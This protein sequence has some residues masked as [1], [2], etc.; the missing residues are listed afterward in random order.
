M[1]A[2]QFDPLFAYDGCIFFDTRSIKPFNTKLQSAAPPVPSEEFIRFEHAPASYVEKGFSQPKS[3]PGKVPPDACELKDVR[4]RF[5]VMLQR[6]SR[7]T[8]GVDGSGTVLK[9]IVGFKFFMTLPHDFLVQDGKP[10]EIFDRFEISP[11]QPQRRKQISVIR[12][13]FKTVVEQPG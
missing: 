5:P 3:S 1:T 13:V 2:P 4:V 7:R 10:A 9:K 11:L 8:T 6:S 12:H